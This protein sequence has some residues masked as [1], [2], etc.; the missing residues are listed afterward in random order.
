[1]RRVARWLREVFLAACMVAAL[2]YVVAVVV[3][4]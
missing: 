4:A 3:M 2:L 1:M